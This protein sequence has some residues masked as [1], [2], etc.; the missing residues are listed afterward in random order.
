MKQDLI[1]NLGDKIGY[2]SGLLIEETSASLEWWKKYMCGKLGFYS[3]FM[4]SYL[5]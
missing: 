4:L 2:L 3:T 1:K 5:T